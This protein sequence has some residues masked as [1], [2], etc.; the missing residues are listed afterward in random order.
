[1][2]ILIFGPYP[3][4]GECIKGGVSS[5]IVNLVQGLMKKKDSEILVFSPQLNIK[6]EFSIDL[7][8]NVKI[9]YYPFR[10]YRSN[11]LDLLLRVRKKLRIIINSFNPDIIHIQGNGSVLL[12][13]NMQYSNITVVTQHGILSQEIK[14]MKSIR[15]KASQILNIIIE[16]HFK[17]R[18][19]NWIFISKY[20]QELA[21]QSS[22]NL[23]NECVIYN[24]VNDTFF[25][26][27]PT[28][29]LQFDRIYYVGSIIRRK[30][31]LDLLKSIKVLNKNNKRY[32]LEIVGDFIE[33]EYKNEIVNYIE[34]NDL[35]KQIIFHGWKKSE[36]IQQISKNIAIFVLPSYQE[37]L[38]IV[39]AEA[40]ASGKTVVSTNIAGIPEM[41]D[42]KENGFLFE[43]GSV[44]QLTEILSYLYNNTQLIKDVS[45]KS[46]EKAKLLFSSNNVAEK[47]YQYYNSI[48][49]K[50]M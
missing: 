20:N 50:V 18:I 29:N 24:P 41:I 22:F 36:E 12:V 14:Y 43:R 40:M 49:S 47:T 35:K 19:K 6:N 39:I 32:Y 44:N 9:F 5:V 30:G 25:N 16:N 45:V 26:E 33:F 38:P 8:K 2:K 37:T 11:K 13:S 28:N 10:K 7:T 27:N 48:I 46:K 42:D 34:G 17:K 1:M 15:S 4:E 23:M 21:K 31:L 3:L